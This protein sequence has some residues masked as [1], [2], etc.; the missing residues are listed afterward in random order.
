MTYRIVILPAAQRQMVALDRD[1]QRRIDIKIRALADTPRPS[2]VVKM[3][4]A[5]NQ[6]RLRV[7]D[8]RVLYAIIDRELVV[9]IVKLDHRREIYR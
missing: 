8:W 2:G 3:A 7:G 6:W 5:E 9:L 4:G 1:M